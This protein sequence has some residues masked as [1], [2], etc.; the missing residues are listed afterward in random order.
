MTQFP[1][2]ECTQYTKGH[3]DLKVDLKDGRGSYCGHSFSCSL[4]WRID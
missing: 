4:Y 1:L 3:F 2:F